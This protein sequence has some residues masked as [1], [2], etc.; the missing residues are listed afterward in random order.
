M[1]LTNVAVV[2]KEKLKGIFDIEDLPGT[3]FKITIAPV[4]DEEAADIEFKSLKGIAGKPLDIEEIR[5]ERL[6]L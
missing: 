5:T 4:S 3:A 2:N 1:E 6:K